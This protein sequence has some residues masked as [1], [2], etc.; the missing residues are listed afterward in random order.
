[1]RKVV[2]RNCYLKSNA[3]SNCD[4]KI[5]IATQ[6]NEIKATTGRIILRFIYFSR[7]GLLSSGELLTHINDRIN[8]N[9]FHKVGVM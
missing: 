2:I 6:D 8:A 4:T 3:E 9:S 5:Q 7:V 1:M